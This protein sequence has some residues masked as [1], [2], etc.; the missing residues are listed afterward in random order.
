MS[1]A[2]LI[3]KGGLRAANVATV[4]TAATESEKPGETVARVA[5]VATLTN[6][7]STT[8][9]RVE[10][11]QPFDEAQIVR[12]VL[13]GERLRGV[14][15]HSPIL[16]A[17]VWVVADS[18]FQPVDGLAVYYRE[19]FAE[20]GTKTPEQLREIHNVKLAFPGCRVIQEGAE[21]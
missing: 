15:I 12:E 7:F 19:E 6:P 21:A 16:G 13:D 18:T 10:E 17:S 20:L 14:L 8:H 2:A 5:S 1:L 11:H 4:A 9:G 3:R